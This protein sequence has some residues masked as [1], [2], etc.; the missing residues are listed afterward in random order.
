MD[1]MWTW[2]GRSFG[3]RDGD[4][5][6]RQDGLQVGRFEGD[7]IYGADGMYLGEVKSGNRLIRDRSKRSRRK[8]GFSPT[9]RTA[10]VARVNYVGN[11]MYVGHEDFPAPESF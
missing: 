6:F 7:E 2:S 9:R 10:V 5:L 3:Y 8:Q 1:W 11:V 4:K